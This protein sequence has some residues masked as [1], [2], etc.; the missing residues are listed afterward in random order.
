MNILIIVLI[1]GII[2]YLLTGIKI[3]QQ[4]QAII[5]ERLGQFSR[6]L[7]PGINF[8]IP[9]FDAPRPMIKLLKQRDISGRSAPLF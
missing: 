2:L 3:V 5:V 8:L 1:V 7:T 4:Q 6:V 9:I